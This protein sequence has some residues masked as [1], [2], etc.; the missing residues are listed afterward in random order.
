[1]DKKLIDLRQTKEY[2][3]YVRSLGWEVDEFQSTYIYVKRFLF[4]KFVKVQRPHD[5]SVHGFNKYL[6]KKFRF[7]TV[8][9]ESGSQFQYEEFLKLGFKKYNSPY[10][11]SK[12]IQIDLTKTEAQL[13]SQMHYKT[14]YNIK[15]MEDI[16]VTKTEDIEKFADFWQR[17]AKDRGMFL[18]QRREIAL[19]YKAFEQSSDIWI[20]RDINKNWIAAIFQVN[21][22]DVSYYMYAAASDEGKRLYAPTI[23]AWKAIESAK[24]K[25]KKIF[26]FEGV[27]DERFPLNSWR[28]FTR[29]KKSFGGREVE[30]PGCL[31]KI[32]F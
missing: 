15:K 18:D 14:R 28:G 19:L 31:V 32:I 1:M 23:L 29:F 16:G 25:K 10:L 12:T 2:A 9:L 13:L 3:N 4:W 8:Y 17:C 5:L 21:T 7:S 20:A 27:F 24:Q 30:Y 11:P 22:N 6:L 26:D